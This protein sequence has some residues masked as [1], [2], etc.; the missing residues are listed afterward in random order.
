MSLSSTCAGVTKLLFTLCGDDGESV[1]DSA[2][3]LEP[4]VID[5]LVQSLYYSPAD[6]EQVKRTY[7]TVTLLETALGQ[8]VDGSAVLLRHCVPE[9]L[10][11]LLSPWARDGRSGAA[12]T[13][14]TLLS[15]VACEGRDAVDELVARGV[16]A[17]LCSL[18][19]ELH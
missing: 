16:F 13:A 5:W 4:E 18:I 8:A 12:R 2:A 15:D 6:A 17:D 3:Y 7:M 19:A 1:P 14:L 9:K 11:R 10:S